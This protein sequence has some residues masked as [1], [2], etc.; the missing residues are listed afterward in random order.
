[1]CQ[2]IFLKAKKFELH[3][4][5][6]KSANIFIHRMECTRAGK[7]IL[8]HSLSPRADLFLT[9]KSLLQRTKHNSTHERRHYMHCYN[10]NPSLVTYRYGLWFKPHGISINI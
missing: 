10:I 7:V 4:S 2:W 1:M 6:G 5:L 3:Q 8:E 9:V